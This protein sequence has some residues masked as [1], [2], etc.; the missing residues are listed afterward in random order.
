MNPPESN[1]FFRKPDNPNYL[2]RSSHHD[3]NR[4]ARYM[5]TL[6]KSDSIAPFGCIAGDPHIKDYSQPASPH[7]DLSRNGRCFEE[8]LAEWKLQYNDIEIPA[9][10]I[11][12]DHIHLCIDVKAYLNSG[13]SRAVANLMGKTT[14]A[15]N[16][17]DIKA[18]SKG[19]NDRIAYKYE[20]WE[21]QIKYV[22]DNPRRYLIKKLFPDLF[23]RRWIIDIGAESF[24]AQGNIML[25]KNP[26]MQVVRFS[27]KYKEGEFDA[28][29]KRWMECSRTGGVL[30][31]PYIHPNEK[32]VRKEALQNGGSIIRV[33]ENGFADR[34]CPQGEEFEYNGGRQLLLIAP[35]LH[36][37]IREDLTYSK[38]QSL[39]QI[40]E[41]IAAIDWLR[42]EGRIRRI[43]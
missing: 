20:I 6:S 30:I 35:M 24:M 32:D 38:A 3:Y 39:N 40:S 8:A 36:N 16:E 27:R 14:A 11:M 31:S 28:K 25:L 4:P 23:Y 29:R 19:F 21:K 43:R 42:E 41:K 37:S 1:P 13:L 18:F 26:D 22:M 17:P 34:F 2:R 15:I 12:P 10:Q 33:C 7:I 5:I 9:Y